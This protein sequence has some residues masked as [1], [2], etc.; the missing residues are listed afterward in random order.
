[1]EYHH[2][3]HLQMSP[4]VHV[5]HDHGRT[6]TSRQTQLLLFS[7]Y[8][9]CSNVKCVITITMFAAV[10]TLSTLNCPLVDSSLN[11]HVYVHVKKACMKY[12]DS[13]CYIV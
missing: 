9:C 12:T 10:R 4:I 11:V 2:W 6:D 5:K 1:M 13:D 8:F 7:S 3:K